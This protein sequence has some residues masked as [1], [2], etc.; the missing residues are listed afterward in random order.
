MNI[1]YFY[2][3]FTHAGHTWKTLV[4]VDVKA[5]ENVIFLSKKTVIGSNPTNP[6]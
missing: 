4:K 2:Y 5:Q 3:L 1:P 6:A